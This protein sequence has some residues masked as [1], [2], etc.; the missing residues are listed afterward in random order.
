MPRKAVPATF[1]PTKRAGRVAYPERASVVP[2][3][4]ATRRER[5]R[6]RES[7]RERAL[8]RDTARERGTERNK[9]GAKER[10]NKERLN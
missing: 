4:S 5:E 6:T 10:R 8:E 7:E 1:T 2:L 9:E 3:K